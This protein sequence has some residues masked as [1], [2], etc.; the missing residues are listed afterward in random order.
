MSAPRPVTAALSATRPTRVRYKVLL[1][2]FVTAF[3]M[4]IDRTCM[5]TATTV[6]TERVRSQHGQPGVDRIVVQL[7]LHTISGARRMDG[8]PLWGPKHS[9]S[10]DG[11]VVGVHDRYGDGFQRD[12]IGCCEILLWNRRSGGVSSCF[13]SARALASRSTKGP[14]DKG[15][16]HAGSRFGAAVTPPALVPDLSSSVAG[17]GFFIFSVSWESF[18]RSSGMR[19]TATIRRSIPE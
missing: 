16:Q 10:R 19:T 4:Y 6:H 7:G 3:I 8:R 11:V 14:S 9:G 2:T 17:I 5:G 15:F 12:V 13:K 18:G 1:L